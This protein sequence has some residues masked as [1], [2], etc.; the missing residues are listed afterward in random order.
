MN[1]ASTWAQRVARAGNSGDGEPM[2]GHVISMAGHGGGLPLSDGLTGGV[3]Y[4]IIQAGGGTG[5]YD[6]G[7][8]SSLGTGGRGPPWLPSFA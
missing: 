8:L 2:S 7:H 4:M 5:L 1:I 3:G 6:I